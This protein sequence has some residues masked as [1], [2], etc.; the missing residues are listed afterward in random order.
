MQSFLDLE[1]RFGEL[2]LDVVGQLVAVAEGRGRESAARLQRPEQLETLREL[3][4]IQSI[5]TS[6]AIEGITAPRAR[7]AALAAQKTTPRDRPEQEIAGYRFVLAEIHEHGADIPFE[8]RYLLQLHGQLH[9]F[10][11]IRH[12][13]SFKRADNSVT[14]TAPD[15]SKVVRFEPMSWQRTSAAMDELHLRFARAE[16]NGTVPYP[17]L[18]AAYVLDFLTIHPFTDGNGRMARLITLWLLY[19][20]GYEVGRWISLERIVNET[21]RDY[22]DALAASTTGWHEN[23]HTLLPWVRY[24]LGV[25]VAAYGELAERMGDLT[26]MR[27]GKRDAIVRFVEQS[28]A[29]GFS[30]GD[31]LTALPV[32]RDYV[33]RV[34]RELRDAGVVELRGAGRGA[35]WHRRRLPPS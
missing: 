31:A 20:G 21:R 28:A 9:R 11:S 1:G 18:C 17:L 35:R 26:P 12:A 7:I 25:L 10:T 22:Y 2:P 29:D 32:S 13:G 23:Q 34:L 4:V 5:E 14:E 30:V 15:G 16:A 3:A 24:L 19:R 6:N 27:A 8:P 33:G